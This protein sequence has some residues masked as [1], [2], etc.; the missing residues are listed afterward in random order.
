M[1]TPTKITDLTEQTTIAASDQIPVGT[2][3]NGTRRISATNLATGLAAL[4]AVTTNGFQ[5]QYSTPVTGG[6]VA[7]VPT[8]SGGSVWL[9]LTPAGTLATLAVV[10]PGDGSAGGSVAADGQ[11]VLIATTQV[12]TALTLSSVG[13]TLLGAPTTLAQFG[14]VRMRYD[15]ANNV[16]VKVGAA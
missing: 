14:V 15:M 1:T 5:T 4:Q 8:V 7:A 11:E 6:S 13:K 12:L 2:A 10:L 16:W 9:R 3:A